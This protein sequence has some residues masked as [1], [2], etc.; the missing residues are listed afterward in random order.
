[1]SVH[2]KGRI[3]FLDEAALMKVLQQTSLHFE[4]GNTESSTVY[5]NLPEDYRNRL[6]KAIVAF[7]VAVEKIDHV[8]KLSQ[9]RDKES[10]DHIINHLG[11]QNAEGQF[12]AEEMKKRK[13]RLSQD[14]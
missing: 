9:N 10:Y 1:M 14:Q 4:K 6:I 11:K 3:Q 7:E 13:D 2:V 5:H 8:F 12:I